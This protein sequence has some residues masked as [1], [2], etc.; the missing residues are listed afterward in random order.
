MLPLIGER[1]YILDW[2]ERETPARLQLDLEGA[3]GRWH[4]VALFNWQDKPG[5]ITLQSTGLYLD[6]GKAYHAREFW[7]GA[8]RQIPADHS[9]EE[10]LSFD[11]VPPHGVVLLAVRPVRPFRPQ[12]LGGNL[13]ISQ[14]LEVAAW[15]WKPPDR[16]L[17][18]LERPGLTRGHIDFSFPGPP[19]EALHAGQA[20]QAVSLG[21]DLY[22][23]PVA[24]ERS[25]ELQFIL[26]S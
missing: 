4:L 5:N 3:A 20:V 21:Q 23:V 10:S 18:R 15:E 17:L 26:E 25:L 11:D 14:G 24:F 16:L 2:F 13:H 7:S 12:Y 9:A 19:R 22:R 6:L 1:P 8:I